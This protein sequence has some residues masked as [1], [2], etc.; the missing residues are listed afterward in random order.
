MSTTPGRLLGRLDQ[1][2]S[3]A[4][5]ALVSTALATAGL[6][7]S[8]TSSSAAPPAGCIQP[9]PVAEVTAAQPVNGLTVTSGTTPEA[10]TGTV[11][12]VQEN[13]VAPGVD[14][15]LAELTSAELVRVGGIWQGMSGSPVY[16]ADGRLIGAVSYG[17]AAGPSP[18]AGITPAADMMKLF[19][20]PSGTLLSGAG[21]ARVALPR[22][23]ARVVAA[24]TGATAT[25]ASAGMRRLPVPLMVSGLSQERR[26][27][28]TKAFGSS[29]TAVHLAGTASSTPSA[30]IVAG[31]NVA[32]S[33]SYGDLSVVGVGTATAVC[34]GKVIAFGHPMNHTGPSQMTLHG[35]DALYIQK[36]SLGAPFKVANHNAPL[37]A[38][39]QDRLAG[40]FGIQDAARVPRTTAI[41]SYAAVP[42][43][44]ARRGT[45][46][47][48]VPE[49][50]PDI[51]AMHMLADQDVVFDAIARGSSVVGWTISGTRGNGSPF[52]LARSDR[53]ADPGDISGASVGDMA[54]AL[55]ALQGNDAENITVSEVSTSTTLS[56]QVRAYQIGQVRI[57]RRGVWRVVR[58]DQPLVARPGSTIRFRIQLNS[59]VLGSRFARVR[60]L[61]PPLARGRFGVLEFT[62]GNT[63]ME[64]GEEEGPGGVPSAPS[65]DEILARVAK[66]PRN[67][68]VVVSLSLFREDGR[69]LFRSA[70]LPLT[71]VVNGAFAV[72]M[73]TTY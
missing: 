50:L 60:V 56:R 46:R 4:G 70:R 42:G 21:A 14:M 27:L 6:A 34:D 5:I 15:I 64:G 41:T 66:A 52:T 30:P 72:E 54:A 9:Y 25:E 13:G 23:L 38:V 16:A 33:V 1:R 63:L 59:K 10:F 35:A 62:G 65:V 39:T 48:S 36:D 32:A 40:L 18:V 22:S 3:T 71:T 17:L 11:I 44:A 28:A 57:L 58:A 20:A 12:G 53:F 8:P 47:V 43:E 29:R 55:A 67:D 49:A 61:V 19:D 69:G 45:T 51:A 24:T 2:S 37:G 68:Q 31:G 26:G 73:V 7:L